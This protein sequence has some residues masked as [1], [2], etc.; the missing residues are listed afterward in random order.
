MK[1]SI[2]MR[3]SQF[4]EAFIPVQ[5][6]PFRFKD[7]DPKRSWNWREHLLPIY[8]NMYRHVVLKTARQVEKSTTQGNRYITYSALIPYFRSIYVAPTA[9]QARIFSNDRLRKSIRTSDFITKYFVDTKT[10][11]QVFEQSFIN[12]STVFIGYA[13]LSADTVRGLSGDMLGLDEFQDIIS[14][15]IPVLREV[16]TASD[17]KLLMYTGTPKTMDN[18][19][20]KEWLN[21]FQAVWVI[22]CSGCNSYNRMDHQPEKLIGKKGI[23]CKKCGKPLRTQDGMWVKTN[24]QSKVAGFHISQLQ[25]ARIQRQA[26]WEDL[27]TKVEKY[28]QYQVYNEIFGL[29]FDSA[30]KPIAKS[31][32]Q[33]LAKGPFL[34]KPKTGVTKGVKLFMGVDWGENKGS[35]TVI[36][37]GG[38]VEDK[39][40]IFFFHKFSP[41]DQPNTVLASIVRWFKEFQCLTMG[42]DHGA[43][44]KENLRLQEMLGVERVWEIFHASQNAA[45]KWDDERAMYIVDRTRI[46]DNLIIPIQE[47]QVI[48]PAWEQMG[49]PIAFD[50]DRSFADDF[51][52]LTKEYSER[53]R[54]FLYDHKGPDDG[55]QATLYAKFVAHL[56]LQKPFI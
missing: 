10:A 15:N 29:S 31:M 1:Q 38:F 42:C 55:F 41:Q 27:V 49:A 45:W 4:T 53:S 2:K 28:P 32:I 43:G 26:D 23:V 40:Q 33:M 6:S 46:M 24:P 36:V 13:F 22:K 50:N 34:P 56:N 52:S 17:H 25:T 11:D 20:E 16:L 18:H 12:E 35:F 47:G 48:F 44:H 37:I 21:S 5:G 30:E 9:K 51:S 19:L 54:K 8:D 7:K 3:P 39:F 14:D